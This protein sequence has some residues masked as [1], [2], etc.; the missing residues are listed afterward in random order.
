MENARPRIKP[1]RAYLA[2]VTGVH[3]WFRSSKK[4]E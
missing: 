1:G 3:D 4:K 2:R